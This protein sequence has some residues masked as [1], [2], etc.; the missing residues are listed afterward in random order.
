MKKNNKINLWSLAKFQAI[1]MALIGLL[2]GVLY[3]FGGLIIDTLVSLGWISSSETP[4]LSYGTLLA[5]GAL[6]GMPVIGC[7]IGF[8][9]GLIEAILY[10]LYAGWFG[11]IKMDIGQ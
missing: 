7:V 8:V 1:L 2:L 11:G 4:G 6:I 3:S 10:N 5:L 9:L